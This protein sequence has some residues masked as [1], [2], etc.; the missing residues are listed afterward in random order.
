MTHLLLLAGCSVVMLFVW[1][2]HLRVNNAGWVDV[3]WSGLLAGLAI[4][5]GISGDGHIIMRIATTILGGLW[6][7]RLCHHLWVRVAGEEEDGRYREMRQHL[8]RYPQLKWLLF[9]LAQAVLA[10]LFGWVFWVVANNPAGFSIWAASGVLLWLVSVIGE[11]IADRQL[12]AFK[13]DPGNRGK[14]CQQGLWRYSRHPNY[15]FEWLHWCSYPLLAIGSSFWW[16]ALLGPIAMLI[17]LY[18]VTG[19]PYTEQQS[20]RSRG[21]AY[22]DYQ[23][24]TSAFFPWWPKALTNKAQ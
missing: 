3:A 13:N 14:V 24:T 17:F 4:A 7:I 22:K 11:S 15:F 6:G 19:I 1:V 18:R 21:Q 16:L 23:H 20:L 5:Y 12:A 10:W 8:G 9:F 2:Y